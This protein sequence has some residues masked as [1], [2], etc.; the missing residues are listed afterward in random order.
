MHTSAYAEVARQRTARSL[1]LP[2]LFFFFE[3]L[4]ISDDPRQRIDEMEINERGNFS[5]L[6][7]ASERRTLQLERYKDRPFVTVSLG[8]SSLC[9]T[10][11]SRVKQQRVR[12]FGMLIAII[13]RL[14]CNILY[15]LFRCGLYDTD[16]ICPFSLFCYTSRRLRNNV[17]I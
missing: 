16:F 7:P 9:W 13:L 5:S 8:W 6:L 14:L 15:S 1:F 4:C 12:R 3:L 2:L 17:P 10:T 11:A